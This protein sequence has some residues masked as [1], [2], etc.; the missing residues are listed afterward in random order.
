MCSLSNYYVVKKGIIPGIYRYWNECQEQ[1][2]GYPG[3]IYKKFNNM[4]EASKFLASNDINLLNDVSSSDEPKKIKDTFHGKLK[5][6]DDS[7]F[8]QDNN[9]YLTDYTY[10]FCDGS[11]IHDT[12][13]KSIRCGFG[14]FAIKSNGDSVSLSQELINSGTNNLAELNAILTGFKIIK[15]IES[16]QTC[17]IS[18]SKYALNCLLVWS[19]NWKV[20]NW[21]T[22]KKTP[23]ENADLIKNMINIYQDLLNNGYNI[24]FKHINS[25]Q[26]KPENINSYQYLLWYGNEMADQLARLGTITKEYPEPQLS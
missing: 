11:A 26:T 3:A 20:N 8:N 19:E 5:N 6:K 1:I 2:N 7:I 17:I 9:M 22:S 24:K 4:Q 23:V 12:N 16:K 15:K 13:Y 14:I 18:D 21:L 10:M 25:H